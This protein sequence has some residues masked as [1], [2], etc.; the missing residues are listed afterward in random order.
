MERQ[1][2][3]RDAEDEGRIH[4]IHRAPP[5]SARLGA[6]GDRRR[7]RAAAPRSPPP[8][9]HRGRYVVSASSS[10][11]YRTRPGLHVG[12]VLHFGPAIRTMIVV[13]IAFG[14]LLAQP[15]A[16]EVRAMWVQRG[17][18]ASPKTIL[19]AVEMA[20]KGGFNTLIVQV[21]GRGDAFYHSRH[22]P[23]SPVLAKQP[24]SFDP[25]ELML[26]T[27]HGAGL[28]VHAWVNVNLVSDAQVPAARRHLVHTHPEWLMVPRTL[29]ADLA[30]LNPKSPAYLRRLSEY[31]K[32]NS[33]R[34]EGLFLSPVHK[35]A[36]D[37]TIRVVA[38]IVSRYDLDGIHLDYI[39]FPSDEFDYSAAVLNDFRSTVTAD[40][41][42][43]ERR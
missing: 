16:A 29:A 25:L 32:A 27:A 22:E 42:A 19:A 10:R 36:V 20:R 9:S 3:H 14:S 17:S 6:R 24:G 23:R 40:V 12:R 18:L 11:V 33:D 38:D 4:A 31:A 15:A 30:R 43:A 13:T 5:Q 34:V 35:G 2:R 37:H 41:S 39:R 1:G 21:R 26:S 8:G 7:H 28:E